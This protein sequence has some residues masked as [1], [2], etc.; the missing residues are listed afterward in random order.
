[1]VGVGEAQ[2][3]EPVVVETNALQPVDGPVRHPVRVVV[4]TRYSIV[5][6]LGCT[7][8]ATPLGVHLQVDAQRRKETPHVFR[9]VLPQP[10]PVVVR[11]CRAVPCELHVLKAPVGLPALIGFTADAHAVLRKAEEGIQEGF[12][13][14]LP[15]EASPPSSVV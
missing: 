1:M 8:V 2:P 5:P 11:S 6:N 7:A 13:V 3:A 12:E 4:L 14:G 15:E 9:L 10:P